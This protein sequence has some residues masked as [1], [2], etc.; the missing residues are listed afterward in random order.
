MKPT[1]VERALSISE[2]LLVYLEGNAQGNFWIT[3]VMIDEKMLFIFIHD[4]FFFKLY[5]RQ[6]K[7]FGDKIT[8]MLASM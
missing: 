3:I 2:W 8:Y 5:C 4:F 7:G 6:S 1:L